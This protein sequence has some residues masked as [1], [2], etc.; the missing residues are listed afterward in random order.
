MSFEMLRWTCPLHYFRRT[1]TRDTEIRG[2]QIREGDRVV[3]MTSLM[4]FE[5]LLRGIPVTTFG[6]PFY[7]GWGLTR[8]LGILLLALQRVE[9]PGPEHVP[10]EGGAGAGG[11]GE[12]AGPL[13]R[14][15]PQRPG[16]AEP[17]PGGGNQLPDRRSQDVGRRV[18]E[19]LQ[20]LQI[21]GGSTTVPDQFARLLEVFAA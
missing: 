14:V 15:G 9:E 10:G 3:C 18:S 6:R 21:T 12:G 7:A 2:Q 13:G 1:A 19:E 4:G 5:A 16:Q 11:E 20:G 8:D 17:D